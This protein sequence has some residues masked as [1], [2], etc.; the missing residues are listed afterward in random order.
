MIIFCVC[1]TKG[2]YMVPWYILC[3]NSTTC[4]VPAVPTV[5]RA[6]TTGYQPHCNC[7][8]GDQGVLS[9]LHQGIGFVVCKLFSVF[10]CFDV[11]FINFMEFFVQVD[12][13]RYGLP[14][15]IPMLQLERL[16]QN[17]LSPLE[18]LHHPIPPVPTY[19]TPCVPRSIVMP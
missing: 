8:T 11:D 2:A 4:I 12:F 17:M 7:C 5:P 13:V 10:P 1:R 18:S 14:G 3:S 9:A 19:C 6:G 16:V 15:T